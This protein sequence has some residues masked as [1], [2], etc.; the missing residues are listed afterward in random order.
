MSLYSQARDII[1]SNLFASVLQ[2]VGIKTSFLSFPDD[3][4]FILFSQFFKCIEDDTTSLSH[5]G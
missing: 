1:Q 5:Q 3:N 4:D 2:F